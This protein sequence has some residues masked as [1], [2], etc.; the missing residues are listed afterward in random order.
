MKKIKLSPESLAKFHDTSK[1]L[2]RKYGN[3]GTPKRN[4]FEKEVLD[5][6][7][8]IAKGGK[9]GNEDM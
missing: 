6:Y 4:K 1:L 5:Y 3:R 8:K 9:D 2:D 7:N